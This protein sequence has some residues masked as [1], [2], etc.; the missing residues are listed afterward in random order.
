HFAG[1]MKSYD[2]AIDQPEPKQPEE[3]KPSNDQSLE[4]QLASQKALSDYQDKIKVWN[5]VYK[6]W[7]LKYN[8]AINEAE[9]NINGLYTKFGQAFYVDVPSHLGKFSLFIGGMLLLTVAVQK[10]KDFL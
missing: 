5:E 6:D 4:G 7:N 2:P 1:I 9:G 10:V 3:P 8:K